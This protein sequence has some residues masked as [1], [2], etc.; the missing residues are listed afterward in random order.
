M[1]YIYNTLLLERTATAQ[2]RM[3]SAWSWRNVL[4]EEGIMFIFRPG[5]TKLEKEVKNTTNYIRFPAVISTIH[6]CRNTAALIWVIDLHRDSAPRSA[7]ISGERRVTHG[8][9]DVCRSA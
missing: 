5:I 7:S 8:E 4:E 6:V 2:R 9:D 3:S 1:V